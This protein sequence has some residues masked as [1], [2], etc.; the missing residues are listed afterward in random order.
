MDSK[1]P[2]PTHSDDAE[3][4]AEEEG[5]RRKRIRHAWQEAPNAHDQMM[6]WVGRLMGFALAGILIYLGVKMVLGA[7]GWL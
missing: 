7:L 2:T 4:E 6:L 5:V 3:K 1:P